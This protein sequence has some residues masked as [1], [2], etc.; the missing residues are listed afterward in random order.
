[1]K[2]L[3]LLF[4]VLAIALVGMMS[5]CDETTDPSDVKPLLTITATGLSSTNTIDEGMTYDIEIIGTQ[6]PTSAKKLEDLEI[7]T[8]GQDTTIVINAASYN[9]VF[10]LNAPLAGVSNTFTF[11]LTD[12][13]GEST[14]K[15]LTVTG[16][17]PVVATPF[18]A[19]VVGAFFHIQGTAHGAYNLVNEVTV[20][21]A[22]NEQDKDMKNTDADGANFSGSW[23]AGT[24]N[25]T[26]FVRDAG[27]DYDNGSVED[28]TA[29]FAA[30]TAQGT[31]LNPLAGD[32]FIAKLR[33]GNDYAVI[34]IVSVDATD[35]TCNCGNKGK[36]TFQRNGF[37]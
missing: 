29:A 19:E 9:Q 6:N 12:K 27:Y 21:A 18:G 16:T 24:G 26:M 17:S 33:G 25:G 20:A 13:A 37:R 28:A 7:Q 8:P 11:I 22:G 32:I 3:N 14:T 5:S 2:K 4:A 36:I 10:T 34:E 15:T 35:N 23:T 1:M 31:I 30:G